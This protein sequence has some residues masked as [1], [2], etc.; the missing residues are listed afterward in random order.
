[1]SNCGVLCVYLWEFIQIVKECSNVSIHETTNQTNLN[2]RL[3][4]DS[5]CLCVYVVHTAPLFSYED[6]GEC[7]G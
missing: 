5:S 4:R 6:G 1:M 3:L 2:R 7:R